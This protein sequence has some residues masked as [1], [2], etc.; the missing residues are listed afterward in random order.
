MFW[1]REDVGERE[2]LVEGAR[3]AAGWYMYGRRVSDC[4]DATRR[5]GEDEGL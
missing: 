1:S 4:E 3:D 5:T 2:V